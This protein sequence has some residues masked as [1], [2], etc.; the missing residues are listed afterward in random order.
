[1]DQSALGMCFIIV[2]FVDLVDVMS[3]VAPV[4]AALSSPAHVVAVFVLVW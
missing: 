4:V 2:F 3:V 1:M